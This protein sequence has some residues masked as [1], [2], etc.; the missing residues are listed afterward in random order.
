[1]KKILKI[2]IAGLCFI[3]VTGGIYPLL[4][5]G[6]GAL[7]FPQQAKGSPIVHQDTIKGSKL[8]GQ[9]FT[10][11]DE[12]WGRP[13]ASDYIGKPSGSSNDAIMS[14]EYKQKVEARIEKLLRAH[15]NR[16]VEEIP[17]D[18]VTESGSGF[19]PHISYE[20]IRF[21]KERVMQNLDISESEL[22]QAI[23]ASYEGTLI[24]VTTLNSLIKK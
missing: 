5:T 16:K 20:A 6:V 22:D 7:I 1:M 12:F 23:E 19:D 21:Q 18:L 13:S 8:L 9:H 11:M 14:K 24:N 15:P 10:K 4:S 3:V 17:T 2:V